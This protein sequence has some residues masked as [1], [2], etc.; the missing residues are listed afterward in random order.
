MGGL[1][2]G[3][4]NRD[5]RKTAVEQCYSLDVNELAREGMLCDGAMGVSLL[6][7]EYDECPSLVQSLATRDDRGRA[8]LL[9][10]YPWYDWWDDEDSEEISLVVC[11]KPHGP[12]SVVCDGG[13]F[14]RWS[15]ATTCAIAGSPSSTCR[16]APVA[17]VAV[18]AMTSFTVQW[19][20]C[21]NIRTVFSKS[22]GSNWSGRGKSVDGKAKQRPGET[23]PPCPK[24]HKRR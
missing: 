10:L 23:L 15:L 21:S 18:I 8:G 4:W 16:R 9:L 17:L 7:N 2:S 6:T 3:R 5:D 1:G 11:C 12:I 19:R 20:T 13:S 14:V 22:T 24:Q